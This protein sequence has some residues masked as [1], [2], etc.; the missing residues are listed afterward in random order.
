M[1]GNT[2]KQEMTQKKMEK[3]KW[4]DACSKERRKGGKWRGNGNR[5]K[6]AVQH[7]SKDL[8]NESIF[9]RLNFAVR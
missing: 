5:N 9:W 2:R 8:R 3:K 1:L 4:K 6:A 7:R